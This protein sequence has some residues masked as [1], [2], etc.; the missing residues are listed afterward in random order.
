MSERGSAEQITKRP[1]L[2]IPGNIIGAW[3]EAC[4]GPGWR[5]DVVWV[6]YYDRAGVAQLTGIQ[7]EDHTAEMISLFRVSAAANVAMARAVERALK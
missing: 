5:N 1:K 4:S 7:P 3:A 2:E 6:A